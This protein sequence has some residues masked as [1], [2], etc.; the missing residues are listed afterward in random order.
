[1]GLRWSCVDFENGVIKVD[2]QLYMPDKGGSY[3]LQPLKNMKSRTI[4]PAPFVF[5]ILKCERKKSTRKTLE[6]RRSVE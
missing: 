1:M 5:R 2:K 3:T 6:G 4:C